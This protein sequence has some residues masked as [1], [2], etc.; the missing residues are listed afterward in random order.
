M[1]CLGTR[2]I[3]FPLR[4]ALLWWMLQQRL[5]LAQAS[6]NTAHPG[7]ALLLLGL[8]HSL[9]RHNTCLGMWFL[10]ITTPPPPPILRSKHRP[11]RKSKSWRCGSSRH[12]IVFLV[13]SHL[14][15]LLSADFHVLL[16]DGSELCAQPS[17][18]CQLLLTIWFE[19]WLLHLKRQQ[20]SS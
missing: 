10:A 18:L 5:N 8:H 19:V 11:A 17:K 15:T 9:Q 20:T 3:Y 13:S 14:C 4:T 12:V 7:I 16:L 2:L 6:T 1:F